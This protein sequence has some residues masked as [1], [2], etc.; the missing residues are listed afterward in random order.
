MLALNTEQFKVQ[1]K[2]DFNSVQEKNTTVR[3]DEQH[4]G[5]SVMCSLDDDKVVSPLVLLRV[6]VFNVACC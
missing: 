6:M 5:E 1:L 2:S 4:R 3:P